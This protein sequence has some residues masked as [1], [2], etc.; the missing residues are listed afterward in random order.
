MKQNI[1]LT[2]DNK[3]PIIISGLYLIIFGIFT[4]SATRI[5][6]NYVHAVYGIRSYP[7]GYYVILLGIPIFLIIY[8]INKRRNLSSFHKAILTFFSFLMYV[9]IVNYVNFQ[10]EFPHMS[11]M[12]LLLISNLINSL[13]IFVHNTEI[14][15]IND[16]LICPLAK[17]EKI[18]LKHNMWSTMLTTTIISSAAFAYTSYSNFPNWARMISQSEAAR[19]LIIQSFIVDLVIIGFLALILLSE[20]IRKIF[21]IEDQL[22]LIK[23]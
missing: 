5:D 2:K 15:I 8:I 22:N 1:E 3:F 9:I 17:I 7:L 14:K 21:Y 6:S 13:I 12:G 11:L 16:E 18:K 19:V 10:P 20:I 23:E 4:G